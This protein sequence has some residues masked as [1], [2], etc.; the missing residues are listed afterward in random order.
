VLELFD[1]TL[2]GP[3][4]E[5]RAETGILGIGILHSMPSM[6]VRKLSRAYDQAYEY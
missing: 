6:G 5:N 2:V 3:T 1:G 4:L